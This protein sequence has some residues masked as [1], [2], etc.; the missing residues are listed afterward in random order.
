MINL[1]RAFDFDKNKFGV[2]ASECISQFGHLKIKSMTVF[3]RPL[4]KA[5][6]MLMNVVTWGEVQKRLD[7][8]P[9]DTLFH[10]GC[11]IVLENGKLIEIDKQQTVKIRPSKIDKSKGT[12]FIDVP[13]NKIVLFAELIGRTL[14]YMGKAK[15]FCMMVERII[16]KIL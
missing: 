14:D 13:I 1:T 15:F 10:L 7:N 8:S 11:Y 9:Y 4:M 2:T 3:R 6:M 16:V 12:E 5:S